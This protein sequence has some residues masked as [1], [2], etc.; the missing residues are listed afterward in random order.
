MA[1]NQ[2]HLP[3]YLIMDASVCCM[4]QLERLQMTRT[5]TLPHLKHKVLL[6][7]TQEL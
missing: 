3:F 4:V 2:L 6:P 7:R 1:I 5:A